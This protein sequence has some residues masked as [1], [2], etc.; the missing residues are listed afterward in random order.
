MPFLADDLFDSSDEGRAV[1]MLGAIAELARHTQILLFTHH[2][3]VVDIAMAALGKQ[4]QVH[5]LDQAV[6]AAAGSV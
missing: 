3:H 5:R 1:A 2:A 6:A 4:V